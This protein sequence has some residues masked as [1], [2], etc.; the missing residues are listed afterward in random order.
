[1]QSLFVEVGFH[2]H[3]TLKRMVRESQPADAV[4]GVQSVETATESDT[5]ALLALLHGTFDAYADSI[6]D[7]V[8]L[9]EALGKG[10]IH[11]VRQDGHIAAMIFLELAGQMATV[12]YWAVNSCYR[13]AGLG[14]VVMRHALRLAAPRRMNLWVISANEDAIAKYRHFG[15]ADD[16]MEDRIMVLEK[17]N[18]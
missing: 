8:E 9:R 5:D 18:I 10:C 14:A 12:R 13:N 16:G 2:H 7:E 11:C 15:F 3:K 4:I 6:P 17:E 1:M